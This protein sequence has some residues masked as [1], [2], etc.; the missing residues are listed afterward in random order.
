MRFVLLADQRRRCSIAQ[1]LSKQVALAVSY[2]TGDDN[3]EEILQRWTRICRTRFAGRHAGVRRDP[4]AVE[5][6]ILRSGWRPGEGAL[7]STRPI[8]FGLIVTH[9]CATT[10]SFTLG[11]QVNVDAHLAVRK[12]AK[13]PASLRRAPP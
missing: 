7:H 12:N 1:I 2:E 13:I 11:G 9:P 10:R 4:Q 6:G 5:G 3:Y 8:P